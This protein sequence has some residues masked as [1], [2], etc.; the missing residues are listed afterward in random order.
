MKSLRCLI[1]FDDKLCHNQAKP[2]YIEPTQAQPE[3]N[4][5]RTDYRTKCTGNKLLCSKNDVVSFHHTL[6]ITCNHSRSGF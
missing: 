5:S 4:L 1:D 3:P 2:E 6:I